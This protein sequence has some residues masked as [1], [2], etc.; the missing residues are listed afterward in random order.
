MDNQ[1][2]DITTCAFHEAGH[3]ITNFLC[4]IPMESAQIIP[5]SGVKMSWAPSDEELST[6]KGILEKWIMSHLG[7]YIAD[8]VYNKKSIPDT[9]A[10]IGKL[11]D[12]DISIVTIVIFRFAPPNIM[13]E[14][15]YQDIRDRLQVKLC[16]NQNWDMIRRFAAELLKQGRITGNDNIRNIILQY[17]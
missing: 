4:G 14:Q 1:Y 11:S 3:V 13:P 15:Y 5:P 7:G 12:N 16:E 10:P 8:A 2:D 17:E 6:N 9:L